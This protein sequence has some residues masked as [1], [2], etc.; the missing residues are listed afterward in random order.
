[1]VEK[2]GRGW[3]PRRDG[4]VRSR[5]QWRDFNL[6]PRRLAFT[7]LNNF[8]LWSRFFFFSLRLQ[9]AG[10]AFQVDNRLPNL[11]NLSEDPQLS[12]TLLY[13]IKEGSTAVG[14][15]SPAS[16][17]DIQLSGVLVADHH[18]WVMGDGHLSLS[19]GGVRAAGGT[20]CT[21]VALGAPSPG[22]RRSECVV[23]TQPCPRREAGPS[24]LPTG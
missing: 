10:I 11:V 1:M 23:I 5:G 18:W 17:P 9:K 3:R 21:S 20:R 16:S 6:R 4:A 2:G 14:R 13:V 8:T 7:A 24:P 12:E 15:R 22:R 19:V